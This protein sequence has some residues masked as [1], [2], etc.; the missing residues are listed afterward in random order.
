MARPGRATSSR[1]HRGSQIAGRD[2]SLLAW[3]RLRPRPAFCGTTPPFPPT[4]SQSPQVPLET[5]SLICLTSTFLF[6]RHSLG[7]LCAH[8]G[9]E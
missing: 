1:Q 9:L 8:E 5:N 6:H 7:T 4:S 2:P 3:L